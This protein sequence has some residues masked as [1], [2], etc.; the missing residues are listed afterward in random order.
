M[1]S[2]SSFMTDRW[3]CVDN[4]MHLLKPSSKM[5]FENFQLVPNRSIKASQFRIFFSLL[6]KALMLPVAF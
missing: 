5:S 3:G 2:L 6:K 4:L 1:P